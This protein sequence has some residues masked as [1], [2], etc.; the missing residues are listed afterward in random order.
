MP[1]QIKHGERFPM[2]LVTG[3]RVPLFSKSPCAD[4][5]RHSQT[6]YKTKR[7]IHCLLKN[8]IRNEYSVNNT[9]C[10]QCSAQQYY[11]YMQSISIMP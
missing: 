7:S 9:Y 8:A 1:R 5:R 6:E 3:S 10:V 4:I 2:Y 11:K